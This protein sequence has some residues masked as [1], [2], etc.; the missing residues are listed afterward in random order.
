MGGMRR[1]RRHVRPQIG[2]AAEHVAY[3]LAGNAGGVVKL[4]RRYADVP[5]DFA[6]AGL[7]DMASDH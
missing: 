1:L 2:T 6:G 3:R 7:V 4:M 5:M